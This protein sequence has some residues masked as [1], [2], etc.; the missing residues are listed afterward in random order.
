MGSVGAA[1]A[2]V[3]FAAAAWACVSG[4]VVN[5]STI[6]AKPGQEVG[7]TGT[8]FR[9][10]TDQVLVRFNALD[11]PV[12]TTGTVPSSGNV[13]LKFT[14]PQATVPGN[15]V[16]IVTQTTADGKLSLS[17]VR[18]VLSVTGDAGAQPVV[19]ATA[20]STDTSVRATSLARDNQSISTGSLALVALGVGGVGM[21][22]AGM[23]AL[24]AGRRGSSPET[25]RARS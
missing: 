25:A 8:G 14:V 22:I 21:F 3:L 11:G 18:A 1:A 12:L 17:P 16:V 24:F 13:D 10:T 6:S 2:G 5:L 7:L 15:Y 4:P 19:G 9:N 20:A 23:A